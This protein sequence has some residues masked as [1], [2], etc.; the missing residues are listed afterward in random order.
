VPGAL[1]RWRVKVI[2]APRDD[3]EDFGHGGVFGESAY[4]RTATSTSGSAVTTTPPRALMR[5]VLLVPAEHQRVL[6]QRDPAVRSRQNE[7]YEGHEYQCDCGRAPTVPGYRGD[8]AR[9]AFRASLVSVVTACSIA[10][11]GDWIAATSPRLD[12][13]LG[14]GEI[15]GQRARGSGGV[16]VQ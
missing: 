9:D 15:Q 16:F 1:L 10:F 7:R 3:G 5:V 13:A 6:L 14:E 8:D 2:A 11:S 4:T 12:S